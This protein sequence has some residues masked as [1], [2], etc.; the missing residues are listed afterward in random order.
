MFSERVWKKRTD[1][2]V[3]GRNDL[4]GPGTRV[5]WPAK[6]L[7]LTAGLLYLGLI[8]LGVLAQM[9]RMELIVPGDASATAENI[10]SSGGMLEVALV[11]DIVMCSCFV[12]LGAVSYVMFKKTHDCVAW[13]MLVL[14]VVSGAYAFYNLHNVFEAVQMVS[15][16][17][18]LTVAEQESV[19]ALLNA[20]EDGTY[21]AQVIGWGPWLVPL[22]YLGYRSR[23]VPK[24]IG[25]ILI[26]GGIGLTAQGLQYFLLPDMADLFAPGV[27]LSIIGEFAICAWFIYSGIRRNRFSAGSDGCNDKCAQP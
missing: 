21:I 19:L 14:V 6:R 17:G 5:A 4:D 12:A 9:L 11:S 7:V 15:G 3:T 24:A 25:F 20:H 22:G 10:I 8:L 18:Q 16:A 2:S 27:V 1:R 13:L 23:L 26:A